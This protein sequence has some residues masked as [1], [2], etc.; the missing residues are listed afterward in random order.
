MLLGDIAISMGVPIIFRM[1]YSWVVSA[2]RMPA[3]RRTQRHN[4]GSYSNYCECSDREV[5]AGRGS[6]D[7]TGHTSA[8]AS[9]RF[10]VTTY[11]VPAHEMATAA[12]HW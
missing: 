10:A 7:K 4:G 9:E 11:N 12:C 1:N 8:L 3:L 2:G 6:Q 5:D